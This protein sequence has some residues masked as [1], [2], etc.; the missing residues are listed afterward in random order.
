MTTINNHPKGLYICFLTE[1]WERF[2]FYGLKALL[3][4]YLTEHFLFTDK[5]ATNIFGNY[6]ALVYAF[7]LLGGYLADKYLGTKKAV[8][9]GAILLCVG[10]LGMAIEG[11]PAF[12]NTSGNLIQ[13]EA[14]EQWHPS[15]L[16]YTESLKLSNSYIRETIVIAEMK[17]KEDSEE[18]IRKSLDMIS[19][20]RDEIES[21]SLMSDQARP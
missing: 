12:I 17:Q 6:F 18:Q 14:P 10:H 20:M 19:E 5:Q 8:T 2:S 9:F 4:F 7:P 13:S 15:Y 3:I 16:Q 11:Q 1:M 21:L